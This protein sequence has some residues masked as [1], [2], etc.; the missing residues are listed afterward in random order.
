MIHFIPSS[1]YTS[2]MDVVK[3]SPDLFD[4][5]Y[6]GISKREQSNIHSMLHRLPTYMGDMIQRH[7]ACVFTKNTKD[8][9]SFGFNY[10]LE[11]SRFLPDCTQQSSVHAEEAA[12][13]SLL[14]TLKLS[15]SLRR[16]S[17]GKWCF[18]REKNRKK[19]P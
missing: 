12:I 1:S 15:D 19:D 5:S 11:P 2:L 7:I 10:L 14:R 17:Y 3:L 6:H 8:T 9:F 4:D 16:V 18:L 13:R